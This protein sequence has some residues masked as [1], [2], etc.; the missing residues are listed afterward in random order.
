MCHPLPFPEPEAPSFKWLSDI[1]ARRSKLMTERLDDPEET[2]TAINQRQKL[3]RMM[4]GSGEVLQ[5]GVHR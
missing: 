4:R 3:E 5:P 1:T 2:A